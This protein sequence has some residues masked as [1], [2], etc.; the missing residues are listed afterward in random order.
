MHLSWQAFIQA[1]SLTSPP[2]TAPIL[3]S[4]PPPTEVLSICGEDALT[5]LQGQ[6]TCDVRQITPTRFGFGAL[7]N[8]QG[9]AI[10]TFQIGRDDIGFWLLLAADLAEKVMQRLKLY[11]LRSKVN[12]A[13]AE[14]ALFGIMIPS[15]IGRGILPEPQP[16]GAVVQA[17]GLNWLKLPPPGDR[18]L[19]LGAPEAVQAVWLKLVDTLGA[20]ECPPSDWQLADIRAGLPT[21]TA[22]TSEAFLPQMLNLDRIGGV[23]FDKGCYVGQE[24]IARTHYL[25]QVKRRLYRVRLPRSQPVALGTRLIEAGESVGQVVNAAPDDG[26]QEFLAVVRCDRAHS[27]AIRL[28]GDSETPLQWL[29]LIYS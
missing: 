19:V 24:V 9:R 5:F 16:S 10:A 28:E 25:G 14:L 18:W 11:V 20:A 7:C 15:S 13:T 21:V 29:D 6:I 23:S 12:I 17:H 26:G 27:P 4:P 3:L 8:P 22:A 2:A 1:R